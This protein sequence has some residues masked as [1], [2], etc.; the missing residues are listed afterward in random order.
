MLAALVSLNKP[1][2]RA[3]YE[4]ADVD[5]PGLGGVVD[6]FLRHRVAYRH[7]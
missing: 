4:F 5:S 1:A 2:V 3:R 6:D 7:D